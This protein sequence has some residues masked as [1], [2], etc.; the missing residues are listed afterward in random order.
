MYAGSAAPWQERLTGS[1]R[2]LS[3]E[4]SLPNGQ[5]KRYTSRLRGGWEEFAGD[6]APEMEPCDSCRALV[7]RGHYHREADRWLCL[8]CWDE[9]IKPTV[10]GKIKR[11]RY[12]SGDY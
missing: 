5:D 1:E 3:S 7:R 8:G 6:T 9:Q 12:H 4:A 11:K 2:D 10:P